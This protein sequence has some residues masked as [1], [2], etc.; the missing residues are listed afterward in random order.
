MEALEDGGGGDGVGDPLDEAT[1]MGPLISEG[2]RETVS[3]FV[4]RRR[5]GGD[6][7]LRA[8]TGPGFWF[9]PTVLCPVSNDD[10]AAREE[11]FGPVACVIPFDGEEEAVGWPTT[12]STGSRDR[13]GPATARRRCGSARAI[14]SGVISIN[15]NTSVRVSTPFGGF[16]QS[17]TAA[18]SAPTRSSTTPRSRTCTTRRRGLMPGRLDGQGLC[19]HRGGQRH[20]RRDRRAASREEG[21]TVVGVDLSPDSVGDLAL[22]ADVTD[23]DQ[24]RGD[25]PRRPGSSCGR[26]D[27]LFNNAGISPDRRRVGARHRRWRPG[28]GCRT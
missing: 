12:R 22:E 8:R 1:E 27:V 15:S 5:A 28:S 6:P 17:G 25:V 10:R 16:K 19:D 13:S 18:S 11:I 7:R 4:Q 2:Q 3:S 9:P 14:D 21:A 20:R 24:V 23:A 26:I